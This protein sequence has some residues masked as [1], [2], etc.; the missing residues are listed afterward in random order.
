M[1]IDT[2]FVVTEMRLGGRERVVSNIAGALHTEKNVAIFSVWR[3]TPF[4][5]SSAPI[6]FD[7]NT[8]ADIN[9]QNVHDRLENNKGI[10][11]LINFVKKVMP[12]SFLQNS[13]IRELIKFL[14]ENDS[15]NVVLTDLTST[16]A[17][18]IRRALPDINIISWVHMQPDAFFDVQYKEYKSELIK[19]LSQID[20]LVSL[21]PNQSLEYGQY[22]KSAVSI[23]NPMPNVGQY[24]AKMD[25]KIIL[26]VARI[27]I[28]HK[29]L[30]YLSKLVNYVPDDWKIK[31]VGSGKDSD[32][33]TFK[34]IVDNSKGKIIWQSAVDGKKLDNVYQNAS[35]FIM[36]SRYEGFPLTLGEAMAHGLPIIAFDLDGTKVILQDQND[37]FGILVD[38]NNV[39]LFGEQIMK[40]A[41]DIK[42]RQQLSQKSQER[43]SKFSIQV[44]I[45]EWNDILK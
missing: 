9:D 11:P 7:G 40:L 14:K 19:G 30:D 5:L 45:E 15:K 27:D 22:V 10:K 36:P 44:V 37:K 29:G 8:I 6:Y 24:L 1:K 23:S 17:T 42:L 18:K 28:N 31:V 33:N 35:I 20:T 32:E 4:F 34:S 41:S 2:V 3:R 12:Y 39:E 25:K 43:V 26:I 16:F 21:T 13:R 38:K